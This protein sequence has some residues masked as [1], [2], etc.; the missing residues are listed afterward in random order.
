METVPLLVSLTV[1]LC[2][3]FQGRSS[4]SVS[5]LYASR[6]VSKCLGNPICDPPHSVTSFPSVVMETVAMLVSLTMTLCGPFQGRP[7]TATPFL[8]ASRWSLRA[9]QTPSALHPCLSQVS[10]NAV[11][12]TVA[13]LVFLTT[14]APVSSISRQIVDRRC[15]PLRL[16][17]VSRC[18][19][20]PIYAIHPRL[21]QVSPNVAFEAVPVHRCCCSEFGDCLITVVQNSVTASS[22]LFR[23]R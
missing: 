3:P 8:Y 7:S 9:R 10:P 13:M 15:R 22:L 16:N 18:S 6:W 20:T 11:L 5:F 1:T 12:E 2:R 23:I 4:T 14:M 17:V 21:S 19:G